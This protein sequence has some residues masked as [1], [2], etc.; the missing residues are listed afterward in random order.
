MS[1]F[2]IEIPEF[3]PCNH[4]GVDVALDITACPNCDENVFPRIT[5]PELLKA[6]SSGWIIDARSGGLVL[7]RDDP[8]DDIP[9]IIAVIQ[10]VLQFSGLMHGGEFIVNNVASDNQRERLLEIN[11]YRTCLQLNP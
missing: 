3:S 5:V 6:F 11:S 7:G 8:E 10:G 9:M 4:C 2:K 1:D